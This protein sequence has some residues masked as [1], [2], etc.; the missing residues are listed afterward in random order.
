MLE[1]AITAFLKKHH[2]LSLCTS[3]D[4]MPYCASCFY[5]FLEGS[6]TFVI[7]TDVTKTRHGREAIENAHVA[8]TVALETK[9]VGKIQGVQF[10]GIFKEANEVE[11]KAYFKSLSWGERFGQSNILA[12]LFGFIYFFV[13][14]MW[15]PGLTF[16][17]ISVV[18]LIVLLVLNIEN[19]SILRAIGIG[20]SVVAMTRA[21]ILYYSKKVLGKEL[22]I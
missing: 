3:H 20:Y 8:G 14:G 12:F 6:T 5:A 1:P 9:L 19:D 10:T 16:L 18:L 21:N 13:K 4:N 11:K 7:A 2:L 17:G 22:W 15:K